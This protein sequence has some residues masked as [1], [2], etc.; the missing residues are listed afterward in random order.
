MET[1]NQSVVIAVRVRPFNTREKEKDSELIIQMRDNTTIIRNPITNLT[2]TF[3]FD[4]SYWSHDGFIENPETGYLS[5]NCG[6]YCDQ[7]R[8]FDDLGK[9]VLKNAWEGYN[10]SL[11]AYGQTGAG[12]SYS[13]VGYDN[14]KGI[15]PMVCEGIFNEIERKKNEEP[16]S[17]DQFKVEISMVEIYNEKVRDLLGGENFSKNDPG[18]KIRED[19]EGRFRAQELK[20][21]P[22]FSY[23]K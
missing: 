6:R 8:V 14:N 15:I 19:R 1:D 10:V 7:Q 13:V 4:Y 20:I 18:L 11:F 16:E 3:T 9:K 2:K 12:K 21:D 22:V 23:K 17:Q 5:D